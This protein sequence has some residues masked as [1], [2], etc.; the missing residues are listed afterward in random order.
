[1]ATTDPTLILQQAPASASSEAVVGRTP[2]E[3]FW[4][5]FRRDRAA[6]VGLFVVIGLIVL[7]LAAPLISRFIVHHGPNDLFQKEMTTSIGIPKGPNGR[8]YFG[9]DQV[10]RDTFI[11]VLYGAR[12]S[13]IVAFFSTAMAMTFGVVIGMIAGFFRGPVD[14]AISRFID[15]VLGGIVKPGLP[16]VIFIIAVFAWTYPARIIRGQ[17]LSIR[18]REFVE[19]ARASGAPTRRIL[20][21]E[22]LPNLV[23][24]IVIYSTILIPSNIL[25]EAYLSFLGLGIPDSDAATWGN[26]IAGA[27]AVYQV[28]WWT[29]LFPGLMLLVTTLAFN[30]L[31]DGLRD[32]LDPR[33]E[34]A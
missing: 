31:G 23:A 18:E 20:F 34:R 10:G 4:L 30:L 21:R 9:A 12:T 5:R 3:L 6:M 2:W 27:Q 22:I 16:L 19:A 11:R 13:L 24:P 32:A 15:I 1:V 33:T 28:A 25:F 7:A 14:T 17:T 8:F 26:M 29:M